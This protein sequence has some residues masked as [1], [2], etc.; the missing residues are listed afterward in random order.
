MMIKTETD[1]TF[2][3]ERNLQNGPGKTTLDTLNK[4]HGHILLAHK[5][6]L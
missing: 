2:E 3:E 1:Q 5:S 6:E 4:D